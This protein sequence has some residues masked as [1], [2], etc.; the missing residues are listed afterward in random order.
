MHVS[1]PDDES[2]KRLIEDVSG[3]NLKP[4]PLRASSPEE[5]GDLLRE[6]WLWA[7]KPSLRDVA[8][9][10]GGAFSH[11][12]ISKLL[13]E[14]SEHPPPLRLIY[15]QGCIRGCRGDQEEIRRW[16]TAWRM[17]HLPRNGRRAAGPVTGGDLHG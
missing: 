6:F 16:T 5:L 14:T 3:H 13:L 1:R 7:G 15:V 10:S 11:G 12:T 2:A 4:D 8:K 9:D 17:V